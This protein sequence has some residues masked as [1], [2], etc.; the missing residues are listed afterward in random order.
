MNPSQVEYCHHQHHRWTLPSPTA[1]ITDRHHHN[2]I[3]ITQKLKARSPYLK[4][5]LSKEDDSPSYQQQLHRSKLEWWL[6][7]M[8]DEEQGSWKCSVMAVQHQFWPLQP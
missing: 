7:K 4:Q 3:N 5:V 8:V 6:V 2:Q 1:T